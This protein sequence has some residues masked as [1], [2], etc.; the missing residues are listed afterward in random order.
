MTVIAWDGRTLAA[1]KRSINSGLARTVTKIYRVG[2]SVVA[3]AGN[4]DQGLLMVEWVRNGCNPETFPGSQRDKDDWATVVVADANGVR[5]YERTPYPIAVEDK[6]WAAGSG[7]DF[8][9]AAMHLGKSAI[10]AVQVAC[11]FQSD[12]GNGCDSYEI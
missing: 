6:F 11:V 12:C 8:A 7:R 5:S 10:E 2:D 9:L 4:L 3:I 1:D